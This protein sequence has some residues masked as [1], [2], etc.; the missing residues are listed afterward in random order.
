MID[1]IYYQVLNKIKLDV[2]VQVLFVDVYVV[3]FQLVV[4]QHSTHYYPLE[5]QADVPKFHILKE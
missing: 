2:D 4:I 3:A 1:V 5:Y